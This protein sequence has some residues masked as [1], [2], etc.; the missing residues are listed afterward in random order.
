[1]I[2]ADGLFAFAAFAA[3]RFRRF[4]FGC[5]FVRGNLFCGCFIDSVFFDGGRTTAGGQGGNY[6]SCQ[7]KLNR[8]KCH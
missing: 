2:S 7:E 4:L 8:F 5:S 1:M 3:F 6:A